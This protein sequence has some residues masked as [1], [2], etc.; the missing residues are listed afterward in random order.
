ME[1]SPRLCICGK[2]QVDYGSCGLFEENDLVVQQLKQ[3]CLRS[4]MVGI[5]NLGNEFDGDIDEV[6]QEQAASEVLVPD[7]VVALAADS[8]SRESFYLIKI[9]EEEQQKLEDDTDDYG[10]VKKGV[11][12]FE[13]LFFERKFD[14][15]KVYTLNEKKRAFFHKE[16]VVFPSVQL[17]PRKGEF[18][19][20]DDELLVIIKYL[21]MSN[22]TSL[23]GPKQ[24]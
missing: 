13:G 24:N 21:E 7:I 15:D 14:S 6:Q 11:K 1:A 22:V 2:C 8:T 5:E 4:G 18:E 10:H 20:R 23:F 19:L 3:T 12:H 16:S 17:K 9:I